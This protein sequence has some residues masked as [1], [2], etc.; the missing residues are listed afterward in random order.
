MIL[1]TPVGLGYDEP[2]EK[3]EQ[4]LILAALKTDKV[5]FNPRP[6]V[7]LTTLGDFAITYELN[8]YI[9]EVGKIP[10]IYSELHKNIQD[11][12]NKAGIEIMSPNYLV[13]RDG[14]D[15]TIPKST[16]KPKN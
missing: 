3:V 15:P 14:T 4:T 6:F 2:R 13:I 1:F 12:C 10:E 5:L 9:N 11:E 8:V 16:Y 7:L